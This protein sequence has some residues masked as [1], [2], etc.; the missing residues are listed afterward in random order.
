[1][2]DFH[3]AAP[4]QPPVTCNDS[5]SVILDDHPAA[6]PKSRP[7]KSISSGSSSC[8]ES[9]VIIRKQQTRSSPQQPQQ[10]RLH[11]IPSSRAPHHLTASSDLISISC[12]GL[13]KGYILSQKMTSSNETS[14]SSSSS[15]TGWPNN[16][17]DYDVSE[18]IGE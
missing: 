2:H 14:G 3:D 8:S 15:I 16:P 17:D 18:V 1:L 13:S 6:S 12:S 11:P 4:A 9:A 7:A 5:P 10:Q